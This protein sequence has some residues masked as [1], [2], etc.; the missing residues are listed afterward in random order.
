MKKLL[1]ICP[2]QFGYH[3]DTYYYCK[4]L[5][6]YFSI[7]YICWNSNL[8]KINML[9]VEVHYVPWKGNKLI[10]SL[11]FLREA[12][13]LFHNNPDI[14]FIKYFK[15][16][17]IAIRLCRP[18][19]N[20]VLDIRTGSVKANRFKRIMHDLRLRLEAKLF[21]NITVISG[22]L[23]DKLNLSHKAHI[24]PLGADVVSSTCKHFNEMHLLYVGTLSNRNIETTV[25]GLKKFYD[26]HRSTVRISYTII[27]S[28]PNNEEK[29][30]KGLVDEF[31]LN[32]IV[33]I[34]R[35]I[36]H[37]QLKP[38]FDTHNIGVSYVPLTEYYD[39]QPV[40]KTFEYLLSGM[41]VIGT[42]TSENAK[43]IN[44]ENGILIGDSVND[45]YDG[46]I[47]LYHNKDMFSSEEIRETSSDYKWKNIVHYNLLPYLDSISKD[48]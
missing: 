29:M 39:V 33:S 13:K 25:H 40:T 27:G 38:F 9:G 8:Q 42:H 45:F 14:V 6:S 4:Y 11:R 37:N 35:R 15:I 21:N 26:E 36:P 2:A 16:M 5:S 28:G 24:L 31:G 3:T 18:S 7:I 17:S 20:Y 23:A 46:L 41:A 30:L 48:N 1:I 22:S 32:D 19:Y 34:K 10:R 12:L 47:K 43:V 44:S